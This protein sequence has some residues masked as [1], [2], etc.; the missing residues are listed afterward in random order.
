MT[1]ITIIIIVSH[2]REHNLAIVL[3]L[4]RCI[5]QCVSTVLHR[6]K[7]NL[8]I[9]LELIKCTSYAARWLSMME[10]ELRRV[11][12]TTSASGFECVI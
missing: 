3:E 2:C 1:L 11:S 9:L 8:T 7:H 10:P 5:I 6:R 12:Y 4:I